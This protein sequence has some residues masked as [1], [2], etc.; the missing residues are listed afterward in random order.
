MVLVSELYAN[1]MQRRAKNNARDAFV[2]ENLFVAKHVIPFIPSSIRLIPYIDQTDHG[3]RCNS[4]TNL[5]LLSSCRFCHSRFSV[6]MS[7]YHQ[8]AKAH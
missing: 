5:E 1:L 6:N 7:P 3:S 4:A 8:P 2:I